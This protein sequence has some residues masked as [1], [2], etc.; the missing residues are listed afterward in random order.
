MITSSTRLPWLTHHSQ[1]VYHQVLL[2]R[3]QHQNVCAAT[4]E[5]GHENVAIYAHTYTHICA[6]AHTDTHTSMHA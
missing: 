6:H 3:Y 4:P 5:M 1:E 2:A